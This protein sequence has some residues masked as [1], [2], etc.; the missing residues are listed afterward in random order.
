MIQL[1]LG[2]CAY[3]L[4]NHFHHCHQS[5]L[6]HHHKP[7]CHWR[8][9]HFHTQIHT[10]YRM[11]SH[12]IHRW[13][14]RNHWR[15]H[16]ATRTEYTSSRLHR[17]TQCMYNSPHHCRQDNLLLRHKPT[18]CWCSHQRRIQTQLKDHRYLKLYIV[19]LINLQNAPRYN[20]MISHHI[21]T[22][23]DAQAIARLFCGIY[24]S[25]VIAHNWNN[26]ISEK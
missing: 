16:I 12:S 1:F 15:N 10:T 5:S 8:N 7:T 4:D 13:S 17:W 18:C 24:D 2:M 21:M 9:L 11:C 20:V 6:V 14:L 25:V 23:F 3:L 22:M 19:T 26:Y